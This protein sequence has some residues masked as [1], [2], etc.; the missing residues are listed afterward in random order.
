[1]QRCK[2]FTDYNAC[3]K[4]KFAKKAKTRNNQRMQKVHS[5]QKSHENRERK[6]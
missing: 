5:N 2:K 4:S 3:Q 6:E 1:M